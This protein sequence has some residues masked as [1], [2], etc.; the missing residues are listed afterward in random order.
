M[1]VLREAKP[2]ERLIRDYLVNAGRVEYQELIKM[3]EEKYR[4]ED[5]VR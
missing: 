3:L 2:I 5:R 1:K 4:V